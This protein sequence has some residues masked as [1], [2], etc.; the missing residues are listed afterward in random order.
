MKLVAD[1]RGRLTC[2][3]LSPPSQ[4]FS[5]ER[6]SDGSIRLVELTEQEVP[7]VKL[8]HVNGKLHWPKGF[9]P[10]RE[11]IVAAIRA[12]RAAR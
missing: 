7:V 2:V 1:S 4:P 6:K 10:K 3:D 8:R 12:D 5:A 9:A 11:Q